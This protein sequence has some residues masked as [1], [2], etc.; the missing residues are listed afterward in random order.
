MEAQAFRWRK[1]SR[2]GDV[3][4]CVEVAARGDGSFGVRDSKNPDGPALILDRDAF[5]RLL[6]RAR[7]ER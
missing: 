3:G 4:E 5:C 1:S 7:Y 6:A 2:S